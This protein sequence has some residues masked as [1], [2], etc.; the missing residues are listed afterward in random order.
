M[1]VSGAGQTGLHLP[2]NLASIRPK[3]RFSGPKPAWMR[4]ESSRLRVFWSQNRFP[5]LRNTRV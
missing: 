3:S 5:L 4:V 2:R 1:G